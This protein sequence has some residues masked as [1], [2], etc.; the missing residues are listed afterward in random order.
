MKRK[1]QDAGAFELV[2]GTALDGKRKG[3]LVVLRG[4]EAFQ[5]LQVAGI[6][7]SGKTRC[8]DTLD[9]QALNHGYG[10]AHV[11]AHGDSSNSILGT[12]Y[13]QGFYSDPRGYD[14]LRYIEFSRQDR[15]LA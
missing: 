8:L 14:R 2:L 3:D 11:D 15:F 12:L 7:G 13:D 10:F 4:K 1:Q 9:L 5:H 6:T